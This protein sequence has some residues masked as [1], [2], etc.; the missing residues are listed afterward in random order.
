[1]GPEDEIQR[2]R[3]EMLIHLGGALSPFNAWLTL[4]G[5]ETLSLRIKQHSENALQMAT[6]LEGHPA[7]RKVTYP[8]LDSHPHYE[9]AK[10]QMSNFGGMLTFQLENGFGALMTLIEKTKIAT[11]ASSLGHPY[12]IYF[13]YPTEI[14]Y[15]T[16][17]FLTDENIS[18][19]HDWAGDLFV[20]LSV[21]L[22]NVQDLIEDFDQALRAEP[23]K[24]ALSSP[25]YQM[26]KKYF[27]PPA[28]K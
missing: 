6:F 25:A 15:D 2:I 17:P 16:L 5:M 22:E 8:G 9:L 1:L 20:R 23:A 4:R 3:K 21:G 26:M 7:I 13:L 14:Y 27:S 10:T 24:D 12:T 28:D 11:F 19:I 18:S